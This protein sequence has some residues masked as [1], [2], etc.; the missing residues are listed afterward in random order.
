MTS[1]QSFSGG[2]PNEDGGGPRID[3]ERYELMSSGRYD[4]AGEVPRDYR[5]LMSTGPFRELLPDSTMKLQ[6]AFVCGYGL[7]GMLDAAA[8]AAMVYDGNWFNIDGDPTTGVDGRETPVYGPVAEIDPDT[9][10]TDGG[11]LSA[12]RGEVIWVNADCREEQEIWTDTRCS[13]GDA[14]FADFQSGFSGQPDRFFRGIPSRPRPTS[15]RP[16]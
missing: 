8:A 1:Y 4:R 3:F 14:S 9:C 5:M 12:I 2:L 7:E 6:V 15:R 10:D 11:F 13:K 16:R